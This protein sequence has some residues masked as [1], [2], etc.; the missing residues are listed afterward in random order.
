VRALVAALDDASRKL[1][2][3][4]DS[5]DF[6]DMSLQAAL[7]HMRVLRNVLEALRTMRHAARGSESTAGLT[8]QSDRPRVQA[9]PARVNHGAPPVARRARIANRY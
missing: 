4:A 7:S 8:T 1:E 2:L 9:L 5:A 3:H 6:E